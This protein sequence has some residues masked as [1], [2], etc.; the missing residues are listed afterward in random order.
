[1]VRN[2]IGLVTLGMFLLAAGVSTQAQPAKQAHWVGTWA[3]SP[4]LAHGGFNVKP[5][6]DV[7]LRELADEL[8]AVRQ[9][10]IHLF[11]HLDQAAF[12]RRGGRRVWRGLIE[13]DVLA[14]R[15]AR[16]AGAAEALIVDAG[17]FVVEGASSNVFVVDGD[18]LATPPELALI[19]I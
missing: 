14:L 10:T 13:D 18:G 11:A 6:A 15:E 3:T 2:R 5:F 1:M 16:R 4:M 7:T 17:G 9:A 19:P 12:E 8:V